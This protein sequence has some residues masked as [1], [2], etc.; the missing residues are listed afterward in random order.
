MSKKNPI[1]IIKKM[2]LRKY[3]ELTRKALALAKKEI[4]KKKKKDA[5]IVIDMAQRYFD[6]AKY[7]EQ[8]GNYVNALAALNYAHGWLDCGNK[9]GLFNVK[10]NKIFVV[11]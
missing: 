4:N 6:D 3:F 9:I 8:K 10:D 5:L 2:K 7:F 11:K 1:N